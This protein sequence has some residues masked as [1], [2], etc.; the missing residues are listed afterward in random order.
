[1]A[2]GRIPWKDNR[3]LGTG[4][5]ILTESVKGTSFLLK[6]RNDVPVGR[7]LVSAAGAR[8]L[9]Q[10]PHGGQDFPHGSRG[11]TG[12]QKSQQPGG[13]KSQQ[14][15]GQQSVHF[16]LTGSL[17]GGIRAAQALVALAKAP[18]TNKINS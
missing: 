7:A 15:G 13:Q 14:P 6:R 16:A 11:P 4:A 8:Y 17:V 5:K 9:Q 3:G 2:S 10:G 18:R 12:G 1:M